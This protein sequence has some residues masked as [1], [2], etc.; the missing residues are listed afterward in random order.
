M[1][2][3][4]FAVTGVGLVIAGSYGEH[5]IP[6]MTLA[7]SDQEAAVLAFLRQQLLCF[8][9]RKVTVKPPCRMRRQNTIAEFIFMPVYKLIALHSDR[10]GV[11]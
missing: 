4:G 11:G 5:K 9:A 1:S 7:L 2:D 6:R 8:A 10:D 3:F